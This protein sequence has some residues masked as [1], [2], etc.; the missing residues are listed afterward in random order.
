[1]KKE[2]WNIFEDKDFDGRIDGFTK[3]LIA[4]LAIGLVVGVMWATVNGFI[5]Q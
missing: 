2:D 4:L 1:M 5:I 3:V